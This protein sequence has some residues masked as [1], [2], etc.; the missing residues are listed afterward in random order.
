M[1]L[2]TF[3]LF[4]FVFFNAQHTFLFFS[5][6]GGWVE[7]N[8]AHGSDSKIDVLNDQ[9]WRDKMYLWQS[10]GI[11]SCKAA[12]Y[13]RIYEFAKSP[14]SCTFSWQKNECMMH[15]LII[16]FSYIEQLRRACGTLIS[17]QYTI[18]IW[19]RQRA[20]RGAH[21]A[22]VGG[23]CRSAAARIDKFHTASRYVPSAGRMEQN[24]SAVDEHREELRAHYEQIRTH[25]HIACHQNTTY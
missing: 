18:C 1:L 3:W 15:S 19:Q 20:R 25:H 9:K 24:R 22:A 13:W 8:G 12:L 16:K 14:S 10:I 23:M 11:Y 17:T 6:L 21:S 5:P 2:Y 4:C 7:I